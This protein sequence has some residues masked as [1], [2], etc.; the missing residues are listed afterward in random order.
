VWTPRPAGA[1]YRNCSA[2]AAPGNAT[3]STG[4]PLPPVAALLRRAPQLSTLLDAL[5]ATSLER[6]PGDKITGGLS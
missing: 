6:V 3:A 2:P 1:A 5:S 4:Q